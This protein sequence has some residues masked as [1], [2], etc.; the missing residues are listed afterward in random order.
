M[1]SPG[2][3]AEQLHNAHDVDGL[4]AIAAPD[5]TFV[6]GEEGEKSMSWADYI[7][8]CKAVFA[9]FPD[10]QFAWSDTVTLDD[11]TVSSKVVVSGTHTGVSSISNVLMA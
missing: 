7:D 4:I 8:A 11:G 2:L 3:I 9:S 6:F 10:I 5:C 1:T